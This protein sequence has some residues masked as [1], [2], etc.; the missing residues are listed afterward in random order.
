MNVSV[1]GIDLT[2]V[3]YFSFYEIFI[4]CVVFINGSE[5]VFYNVSQHC[6]L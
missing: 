3:T 1:F 4:C 6:I 5:R 2:N